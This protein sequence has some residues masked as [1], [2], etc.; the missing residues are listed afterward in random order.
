MFLL[1]IKFKFLRKNGVS[2]KIKA[3]FPQHLPALQQLFSPHLLILFKKFL[4]PHPFKIEGDYAFHMRDYK[5]ET[6]KLLP[7]YMT[8]FLFTELKIHNI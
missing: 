8:D 3:H 6:I 5:G 4:A 1:F 7:F 2:E